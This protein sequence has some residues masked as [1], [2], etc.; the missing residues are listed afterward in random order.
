M[1]IPMA[2]EVWNNQEN[3]GGFEKACEGVIRDINRAQ[4]NGYRETC[5]DPYPVE[6]YDSVKREFQRHGYTF[7]PTGFIG[8][9]WQRTEH[10]CW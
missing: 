4:K 5:F 1:R 10:I 9:V 3:K 6:F 8:G 2:S 7:R